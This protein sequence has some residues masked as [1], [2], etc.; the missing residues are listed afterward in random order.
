MAALPEQRMSILTLG[1]SDV[2]ISREFYETVLGLQPFMTEGIVMYNLGGFALGIWERCKLH[3]DIGLM[4]NTCPPGICPNFAIAYNARSEAEV[5]AIFNKLEAAN[6]DISKHP[7][8]ASW[9]GYSGYFLDPDSNA[10]EVVYNPF[11]PIEEDGRLRLPVTA[12]V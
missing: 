2:A 12:S 10:W 8:K 7:H 9:G 3:E 1:V 6:V 11:W 4:G 5:D